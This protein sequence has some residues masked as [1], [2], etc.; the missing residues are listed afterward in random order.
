MSGRTSLLKATAIALPFSLA[1]AA[2]QAA[3]IAETVQKN[4]ELTAF[5]NAIEQADVADQLSGDGPYTVFA[6]SN[7]AFEQLPQSALDELMKQENR[8]QLTRL[9]QHHVFEGEAIASSDLTGQQRQIDTMSGD[10]L[11]VDG[12]S[13]AVLLVPTCMTIARLGEPKE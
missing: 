9:L 8:E 2:A 6:P 13:R 11:T 1:A 4:P 10:T 7:Q 12:T 5:A 3:S